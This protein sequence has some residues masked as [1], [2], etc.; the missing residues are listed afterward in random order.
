MRSPVFVDF[1]TTYT[2]M[3]AEGIA[4]GRDIMVTSAGL[5]LGEQVDEGTTKM[6]PISLAEVFFQIGEWTAIYSAR[7]KSKDDARR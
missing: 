1:L 5:V 4:P 7:L 2:G 3:M 6:R